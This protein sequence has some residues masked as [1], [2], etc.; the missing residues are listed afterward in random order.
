MDIWPILR[1]CEC[2][3]LWESCVGVCVLLW[4]LSL[5]RL[6]LR[7]ATLCGDW[8]AFTQKTYGGDYGRLLAPCTVFKLDATSV[9]QTPFHVRI[10]HSLQ[11]Y[12]NVFSIFYGHIHH[13]VFFVNYILLWH[14]LH[15][16]Y[17]RSILS[18]HK[19]GMTG[20]IYRYREAPDLAHLF[21]Q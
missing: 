18:S 19:A 2:V 11:G 6:Y 10:T 4:H 13:T 7:G 9:S 1:A 17:M 12:S 21:C 8:F 5:T 14:I 16:N 20:W 15:L 3:S